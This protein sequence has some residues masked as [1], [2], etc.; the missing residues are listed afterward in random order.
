MTMTHRGKAAV[1]GGGIGGLTAANALIRRG[2]HVDVFERSSSLPDTETALGLWPEALDALATAGLSGHAEKLGVL[3]R[4]GTALTWDGRVIG[5]LEN[6][7]RP[8]VL[9]SRPALLTLLAE[10][11]PAHVLQFGTA[12]PAMPDLAAYDVVLGCDGINSAMRDRLFGPAFRPTYTGYTA[13]RGWVPGSV[14]TMSETWGPGALFGITPRDGDL[15]N[16]FAAVRAPAGS[17]GDIDTLRAR[18]RDWHPAVHGI[19]DRIDPAAVLHHDLY[20]SPPLPSYVRGNVALLGDAAHAMAPNLGRGAC[21][22]M[23]D[24]ATLAVL[25]SEHPVP[26]ALRRYDR[27]RKR[28]TQR[29]VR[30]SRLVAGVATATRLTGL[31]NAVVGTAARFA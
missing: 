8:A 16:W 2:W 22:A 10:N 1:L 15:T 6:I 5:R 13:W 29:L 21:E 18:Y 26:E 19:L 9:L 12:A 7:R 30:A 14:T 20:E 17:N 27:A 28:P 4:S 3:Q 23:V 24:G 31:R 25:L 11:L